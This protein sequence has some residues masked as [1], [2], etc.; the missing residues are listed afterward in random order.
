MAGPADE[1]EEGPGTQEQD[2][3]VRVC[4]ADPGAEQDEVGLGLCRGMLEDNFSATKTGIF[5]DTVGDNKKMDAERKE[6]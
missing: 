4:P 5:K 3:I 1:G 2:R 6:K